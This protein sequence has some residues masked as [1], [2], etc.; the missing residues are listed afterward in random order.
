[1]HR[2]VKPENL[3]LC[4]GAGGPRVRLA[5]FGLAAR[6]GAGARVG[7]LDYTAPEARLPGR[8]LRAC[9]GTHRQRPALADWPR[10]LTRRTQCC[11]Q[12]VARLER[13]SRTRPSPLLHTCFCKETLVHGLLREWPARTCFCL[14]R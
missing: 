14:C 2:D 11:L 12:H 9:P 4:A 8:P 1:M 6:A 7:T 3:L 5:D 13:W 10:R